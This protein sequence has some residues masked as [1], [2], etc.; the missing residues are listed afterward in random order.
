MAGEVEPPFVPALILIREFQPG[1]RYVRE[2]CVPRRHLPGNV[3]GLLALVE[4]Y[5]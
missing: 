3:V 5:A 4:P 2:L 1:F